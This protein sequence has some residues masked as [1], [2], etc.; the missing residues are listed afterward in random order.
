MTHGVHWALA[1]TCELLLQMNQ[2]HG[3]A[4]GWPSFVG[5]DYDRPWQKRKMTVVAVG[6]LAPAPLTGAGFMVA[7]IRIASGSGEGRHVALLQAEE[8]KWTDFDEVLRVNPVAAIN[9]HLRRTLEREHK[10]ALASDRTSR[11]FKQYRLN[12][13]GDPVDQQPLITT[14]EWA[15]VCERPVP[16]CGDGAPIVGLDLGG[17]RSWSAAAAIW[18]SGRIES[19]ALA[20][21]C[22]FTGGSRTG[23][24]NARRHL[25]GVGALGRSVR[26]RRAACSKHRAIAGPCLG[27]GALGYSCA[28]TIGR[29]NCTMS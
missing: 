10:A 6:T 21:G 14:A 18:P 29:R 12:I 27:V 1:R 4:D 16:E 13:P 8:K 19:W 5:C 20:P 17:T 23:R 2:E 28:T 15:R 22:A 7:F 11:T 24:P 26:G 9:P 25:C 3:V